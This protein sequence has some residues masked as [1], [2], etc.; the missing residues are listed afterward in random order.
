MSQ[1]V[2]VKPY[3]NLYNLVHHSCGYVSSLDLYNA[4]MG[5]DLDTAPERV[6]IQ[7][8]QIILNLV[9]MDGEYFSAAKAQIQ[10]QAYNSGFDAGYSEGYKTAEQD[11]LESC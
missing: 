3:A 1:F 8:A 9:D 10:Q 4:L 6:N 5:T 11:L 2:N 7:I